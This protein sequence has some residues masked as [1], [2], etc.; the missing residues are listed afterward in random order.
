MLRIVHFI[1]G[2]NM[3]GAETLVKEYAL[4]LDKTKFNVT[5]L[6]FDNLHSP[7]DSLLAKHH[8]SVKYMCDDM[9]L[10][11]KCSL[12]A[13][14]FNWVQRYYLARKYLRQLR[15]D[16][17][18]IH[19]TLNRYVKF[20][21]LSRTTK[22]FYT[23][24]F[25]VDHLQNYPQDVKALR[26]LIAHYPT[27]LIALNNMMREQLNQL[28]GVSNTV[29]LNNGI[30]LAR[31]KPAKSKAQ[32]RRELGIPQDAFVLGHIGRLNSIK[33][34]SFLIK[35]AG[36]MLKQPNLNTWLLLVGDG[37]DRAKLEQ[38]IIR[39]GLQTHA[40]IL[41]HRT[42]IP[43]LLHAM[44]RFVFPSISEG[45]GIAV[46]EAQAAGIPCVVSNAVPSAVQISNLVTFKSL[47]EPVKNWVQ[48]ILQAPPTPQYTHLEKWD[49]VAI[50]RQ[51]E[52][53]YEQ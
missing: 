53:L 51:L 37:A 1:H 22:I 32:I 50:I 33:N 9:P 14:A 10:Y 26:W 24:H 49:I 45:L 40:L 15:P 47:Q 52:E 8:I 17:V 4:G 31:F 23:Q 20:A 29:V 16:I 39:S 28:F 34:Q 18:H 41:S 27:Q 36:Q 46:I 12:F 38:E 35:V 43:D 5:V 21:N 25:D 13:R 48:A 2:L 7:Y 11:G 3:G 19:L 42:D 44:D 30:N 6:C